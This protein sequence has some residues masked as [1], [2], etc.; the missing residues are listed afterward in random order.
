MKI[1]NKRPL[2]RKLVRGI[3]S[4]R[5]NLA[6]NNAEWQMEKNG[7]LWLLRTLLAIHGRQYAGSPF[8][9]IDGGANKGEYTKNILDASVHAGCAEVHA[10]DPSPAYV[11]HLSRLFAGRESV[12][13]IAAAIG[14]SGGRTTLYTDATGS[15]VSS[16][17]L[18]P[19][20]LETGGMTPV[21]VKTA[22]LGGYIQECAIDHIPLLKLDI[23]GGEMGALRGLGEQLRPDK[24]DVI[25]FEYGGSALD[26]GW[27]LK[28]AAS[29]LETKGF[30]F[31]KLFNGGIEL[32][33][34]A[35][36]MENY[37]Y[38][39]YLGLSPKW[40]ELDKK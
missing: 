27:T 6:E 33:R 11:A 22:T 26:A 14:E 1:E 4:R 34:Y 24:I 2:W 13:I 38:A 23:E 32:R 20:F 10:F 39:N 9:A 28:E 31:G 40:L 21:E 29:F 5:E 25:Q 30:I 17:F 37:R 19:L 3:G 35:E 8:I 15:S 36:W 18:R 7:E 16:L 12:H